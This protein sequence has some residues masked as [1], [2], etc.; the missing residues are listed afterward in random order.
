VKK[1]NDDLDDAEVLIE[2]INAES[3]S[4][5]GATNI[6][7]HICNKDGKH[8]NDYTWDVKKLD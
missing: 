6:Q 2:I 3:L 7:V 5:I 4:A 8:F 1:L